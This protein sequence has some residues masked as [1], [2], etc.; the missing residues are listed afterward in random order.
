MTITTDFYVDEPVLKVTIEGIL[1]ESEVEAMHGAV[2]VSCTRLGVCYIM[3]DV[4]G[5]EMTL[6]EA[7]S[8]LLSEQLV[9]MQRQGQ[10]HL[11]VIGEAQPNESEHN[12]DYQVFDDLD[13]AL[14][15]LRQQ[16]AHSSSRR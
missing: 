4:R 6:H 10:L 3:L 15:Q 9:E 13:A 11:V 7:I 2:L 8:V 12:L 5:A 16:I 14:T 1:D